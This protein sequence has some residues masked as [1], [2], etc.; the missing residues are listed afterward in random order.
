MYI[1]HNQWTIKIGFME[2]NQSQ[3]YGNYA[4][5]HHISKYISEWF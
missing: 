2:N 1:D 3:S 5:K 4:N